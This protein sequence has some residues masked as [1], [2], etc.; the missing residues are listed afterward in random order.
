MC[1]LTAALLLKPVVESCRVQVADWSWLLYLI[2]RRTELIWLE[3]G[4]LVPQSF[5]CVRGLVILR[6]EAQSYVLSANVLQN[7]GQSESEAP[8]GVFWVNAH[9]AGGRKACYS[10]SSFFLSPVPSSSPFPPSF[11]FI[12]LLIYI[13]RK[14]LSGTLT[15]RCGQSRQHISL[16]PRSSSA[17]H[18]T[19][20]PRQTWVCRY[21]PVLPGWEFQIEMHTVCPFSPWCFCD[22]PSCICQQ[23]ISFQ[24]LNGVHCWFLMSCMDKCNRNRGSAGVYAWSVCSPPPPA[25]EEGWESK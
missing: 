2:V 8:C 6:I 12:E 18:P 11:H 9:P 23:F 25:F 10:T 5:V 20:G 14:A 17:P 13:Q 7:S 1:S 4:P 21:G 3:S 15:D 19:P 16:T 24:V 22:L